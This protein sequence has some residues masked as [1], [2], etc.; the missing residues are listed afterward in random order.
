MGGYSFVESI[1]FISIKH[2]IFLIINQTNAMIYILFVNINDDGR[3]AVVVK[4]TR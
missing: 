2:L 4:L 1:A 3:I